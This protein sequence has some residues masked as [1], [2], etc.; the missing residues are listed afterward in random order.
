MKT[1]R[2]KSITKGR[3][4]ATSK[5]VRSTEMWLRREMDHSHCSGEGAK[6]TEKGERQ[7]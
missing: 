5:K 7:D 4:E 2:T 1:D 3:E 6:V